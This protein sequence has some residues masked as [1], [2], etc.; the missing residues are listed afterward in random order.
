MPA[1]VAALVVEVTRA[2]AELWPA[3]AE[4]LER[5]PADAYRA[6]VEQLAYWTERDVRVDELLRF[7][8]LAVR[9][10]DQAAELWRR[11]L[12]PTWEA[13]SL[14]F[15]QVVIESRAEAPDEGDGS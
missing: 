12:L 11:E 15:A 5:D 7:I 9:D 10:P 14:A 4:V 8:R 3:S 1:D 13:T 2:F 6:S